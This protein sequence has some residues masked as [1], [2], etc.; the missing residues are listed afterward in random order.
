MNS[1]EASI[2]QQRSPRSNAAGLAARSILAMIVVAM[3]ISTAAHA[4]NRCSTPGSLT[5]WEVRA[6][7]LARQDT[8]DELVRYVHKM[9][10]INAGLYIND[11][12]GMAD[13]ERWA[14]AKQKT[15]L[16]PLYS[17]TANSS[18]QRIGKAN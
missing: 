13:A 9:N 16:E 7:E 3:A 10:M 8:P 6:C 18:V 15:L 1:Y 2:T 12:V 4:A 5:L 11:Y 17:A 14:L